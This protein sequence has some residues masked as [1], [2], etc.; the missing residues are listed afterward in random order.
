MLKKELEVKRALKAHERLMNKHL[1][2]YK[3]TGNKKNGILAHYHSS[4]KIDVADL[5]RKLKPSEKKYNYEN[6]ESY[7][8]ATVIRRDY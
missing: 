2:L 5:G 6:S 4:C 3:K 1:K 7:M 8:N